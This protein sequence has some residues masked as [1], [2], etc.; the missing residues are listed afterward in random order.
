MEKKIR[1]DLNAKG[2]GLKVHRQR[3]GIHHFLILEEFVGLLEDQKDSPLNKAPYYGELSK[4][5]EEIVL[6]MLEQ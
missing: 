4:I 3:K 6:K 2:R 5:L 1:Q